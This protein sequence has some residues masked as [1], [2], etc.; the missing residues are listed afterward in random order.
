MKGFSTKVLPVAREHGPVARE[1]ISGCRE[2]DSGC[3][4]HDSGC[5]GAQLSITL[6]RLPGSTLVV[7]REH[8]SGAQLSITTVKSETASAVA[9][10]HAISS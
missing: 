5:P 1:H 4:E 7:A 9:R 10:E 2:H 3:R 8:V 6:D